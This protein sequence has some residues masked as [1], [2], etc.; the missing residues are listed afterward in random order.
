MFL[1]LLHT[2]I[3]NG[4]TSKLVSK[5]SKKWNFQ[6]VHTKTSLLDDFFM[7]FLSNYFISYHRKSVIFWK[8][9]KHRIK[10][11]KSAFFIVFKKFEFQTLR[12]Y[13]VFPIRM[14]IAKCSSCSIFFVLNRFFPPLLG[15]VFR[16][17]KNYVFLTRKV[18]AT[19]PKPS[20]FA[21]FYNL[22]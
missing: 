4:S 1:T 3:F 8:Y 22:I 2:Y 18:A 6:K 19:Y 12:K 13:C 17:Y 9:Q 10:C 20:R 14:A 16:C 21:R 7:H 5:S 15:S 11:L